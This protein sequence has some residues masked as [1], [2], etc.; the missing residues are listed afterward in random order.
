IDACLKLGG[1]GIG[2]VD[3]AVFGWDA[4]RYGSGEIARRFE[5]INRRYPPDDATLR[6]QQRTL[7]MFAP[8]SLR[9]TWTSQIVRA[10]GILPDQVPPLEFYPHHRTHAAAAFYLSPHEEALVLT[11]DGSGDTDCTTVWRG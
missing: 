1:I 2:D 6:W 8:G 10:F 11:V 7:G 4:P 5:E 9:R 3:L